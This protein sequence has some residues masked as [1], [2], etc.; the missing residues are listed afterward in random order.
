VAEIFGTYPYLVAED[1]NACLAFA[2]VEMLKGKNRPLRD[3]FDGRHRT[4]ANP[5]Q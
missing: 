4:P 5:H 2:A 3:P 1:I